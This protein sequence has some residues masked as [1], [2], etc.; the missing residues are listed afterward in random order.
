M[1][2]D[3]SDETGWG[4]Q[5]DPINRK[6]VELHTLWKLGAVDSVKDRIIASSEDIIEIINTDGHQYILNNIA[7]IGGR[8][9][10]LIRYEHWWVFRRQGKKPEVVKTPYINVLFGISKLEDVLAR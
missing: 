2:M 8:D 10:E 4:D 5:S 1:T 6:W 3:E 7:F 9:T